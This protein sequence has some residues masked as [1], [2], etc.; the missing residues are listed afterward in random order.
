M[1]AAIT[2]AGVFASCST[3][4]HTDSDDTGTPV[5]GVRFASPDGEPIPRMTS[6]NILPL[7]GQSMTTKRMTRAEMGA[8]DSTGRWSNVQL[9]EGWLTA[10]LP[11]GRY[12]L[13]NIVGISGPLTVSQSLRLSF[14]VSEEDRWGAIYGGTLFVSG[15][16]SNCTEDAVQFFGLAKKMGCNPERQKTRILEALK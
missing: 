14:E 4:S 10:R 11:P 16:V 13:A 9:N 5:V 1:C 6:V 2:A 8:R 15:S 3:A 12:M 7:T